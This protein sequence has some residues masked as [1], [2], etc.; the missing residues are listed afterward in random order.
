MIFFPVIIQRHWVLICVNLLYKTLNFF[1]SVK[2]TSKQDIERILKNLATKFST[3]CLEAN[4]FSEV[5]NH[6]KSYSPA[7]Y[8]YEAM[9]NE[10]RRTVS[11]NCGFYYILY[12]DTFDGSTVRDFEQATV[13]QY[14]KIV[15]YKIFHSS[16]NKAAEDIMKPCPAKSYILSKE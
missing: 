11:L 16:L 15:A 3:L 6:F 7:N 12:M 14:W 1:D 9:V 5:F 8:P 10:T 4:V 2:M 13:L